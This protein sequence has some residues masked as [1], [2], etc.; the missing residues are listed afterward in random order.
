MPAPTNLDPKLDLTFERKSGLSIEQLWKGWTDPK[1]LMQ[2]FCPKPWNVT[3]CRI[4]LRPGGEFYTLMEGPAGEKFPNHGCYLE[5]V[6][7]QKLVWTNV[8]VKDFRPAQM[9]ENDFPIVGTILFT[10]TSEGTLYQ[11]HAKHANE[12]DR[13]K[14]EQMGFEQGWGAAFNQL[15]ELMK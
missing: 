8:L 1:L 4:D 12:V 15:V 11:A 6:P 13:K 7:N 10:K 3:D 5:I 9:S 14:H 2:W